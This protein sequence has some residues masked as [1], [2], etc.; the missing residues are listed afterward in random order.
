MCALLCQELLASF[1]QMPVFY[2]YAGS[3]K[4]SRW[5]RLRR[6]G[7][8]R[9]LRF[10]SAVDM[11][12]DS[13]WIFPLRLVVCGSILHTDHCQ[14]PAQWLDR[15]IWAKIPAYSSFWE[16]SRFPCIMQEEIHAGL[17]ETCGAFP[18]ETR[19]QINSCWVYCFCTYKG[20]VFSVL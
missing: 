10:A 11:G 19:Q 15:Q 4:R 16:S 18:R 3:L 12:V 14:A 13:P 6:S 2:W 5:P 1:E 8:C 7:S 9:Q 20:L 17:G